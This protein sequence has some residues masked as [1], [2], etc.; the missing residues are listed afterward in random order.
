MTQKNQDA[1]RPVLLL[2]EGDPAVRRSLQLV[3]QGQGFNVRAYASPAML[4]AGGTPVRAIC[5]V[6]GYRLA[7]MTGIEVLAALRG[8]G[9]AGPGRRS[10][11]LARED[12]VAH[13]ENGCDT[14]KASDT[15]TMG[16]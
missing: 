7:G 2:L 14:P 6:T 12:S 9:W 4:L 11:R 8:C 3:L 15:P 10:R 16:R 1:G 13:T 5:L